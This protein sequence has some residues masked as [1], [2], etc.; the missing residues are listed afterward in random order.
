MAAIVK[1][2]S[3]MQGAVK[4]SSNPFFKSKYADLGS[5]MAAS[6]EALHSHD[7]AIVQFPIA[8]DGM[9]GVETVIV[10]GSGEWMSQA[11]LLAT[12]KQD[13]QA[14]GSA[15]TYARRYGWQAVCGIPSED[16]DGNYATHGSSKP[17]KYPKKDKDYEQASK[18]LVDKQASLQP[19]Q[20]DWCTNQIAAGNSKVVIE[21][22]KG[23]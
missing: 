23:L 17:K 14:Y 5:V 11:C 12:A 19:E 20:V 6:K 1:A 3:E 18:L 9:C 16:D 2:Q 4:G 22:L 21:H 8:A 13:P 15:I 7:L 10:H